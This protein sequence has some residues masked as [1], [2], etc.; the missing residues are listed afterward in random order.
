MP[1]AGTIGNGV[2]VGSIEESDR[3]EFASRINPTG[4]LLKWSHRSG[5]PWA[6]TSAIMRRIAA[7]GCQRAAEVS[8]G[9]E[10]SG[11]RISEVGPSQGPTSD[12]RAVA[13]IDV[14]G[15]ACNDFG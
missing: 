2:V 14:D 8:S 10:S 1:E 5:L 11:Q 13:R 6:S 12:R 15:D 3:V 4:D 9:K 7:L